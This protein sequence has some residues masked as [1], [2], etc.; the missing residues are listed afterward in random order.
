[1]RAGVRVGTASTLF[2][3]RPLLITRVCGPTGPSLIYETKLSLDTM[4]TPGAHMHKDC[5]IICPKVSARLAGV[6]SKKSTAVFSC[7]HRGWGGERQ[8]NSRHRYRTA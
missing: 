2:G 8:F 4:S 3:R 6:V 1:M 7:D 5:G